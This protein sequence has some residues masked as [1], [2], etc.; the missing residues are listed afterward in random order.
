MHNTGERQVGMTLEQIKPDHLRRYEFAAQMVSGHVI[1]AACGTGYGAY[2]MA[3]SP[4]VRAVLAIDI[5]AEALAW[6]EE[7]FPHY[8]VAREQGDLEADVTP[9]WH[10]NYAVS[11]ET[12]EHL[13]HPEK[14]LRRL[15]HETDHLIA[16]VP[17]ENVI[18]FSPEKNPFHVRH[19]TPHEFEALLNS[20]GWRVTTWMTQH[21]KDPG[22]VTS[23]DDGRFLV[24]LAERLIEGDE[25]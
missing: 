17:N 23:G 15:W 7:H 12:L 19:Y 6:G 24:V 25:Q 18:P 16:S 8:K 11:F 22:H 20:C 3:K 5:S 14:L 21:D 9:R 2:I 1:D 10:A 4:E 13:Q